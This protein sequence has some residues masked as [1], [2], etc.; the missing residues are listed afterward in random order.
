MKQLR[1]SSPNSTILETVGGAIG[2]AAFLSIFLFLATNN[3]TKAYKF[4]NET[5]NNGNLAVIWSDKNLDSLGTMFETAMFE[6]EGSVF[7][8][9]YKITPIQRAFYNPETKSFYYKEN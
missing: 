6:T 8:G 5:E 2:C 3:S 1:D 7:D 4:A 9:N